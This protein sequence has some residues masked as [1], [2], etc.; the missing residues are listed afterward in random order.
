MINILIQQD[1]M[2]ILNIYAPN[3]FPGGSVVK[4]LAA[5]AGEAGG[6]ALTPESG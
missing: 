5:N 3:G 4:N 1:Y 6:V 2:T